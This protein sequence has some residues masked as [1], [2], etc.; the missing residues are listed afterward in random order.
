MKKSV[1]FNL[2]LNQTKEYQI[3]KINYYEEYYESVSKYLNCYTKDKNIDKQDDYLKFKNGKK[4]K[5]N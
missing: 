4:I 2:S 3:E 1:S 5:R